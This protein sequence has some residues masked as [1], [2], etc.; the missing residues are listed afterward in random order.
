M[1]FPVWPENLFEVVT[2][3][4]HAAKDTEDPVWE[5]EE[6]EDDLDE[7]QDWLLTP[8]V[9]AEDSVADH[10]V[11][12]VYSKQGDISCTCRDIVLCI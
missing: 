5:A 12:E 4:P 7:V 10:Q 8:N 9:P 1:V 3:D 11:A 2:S 6:D